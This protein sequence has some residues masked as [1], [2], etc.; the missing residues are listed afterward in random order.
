MTLARLLQPSIV[1][2]EDADLIA[3]DREDMNN[4]CS[5]VMLNKLLN[6]MD[7][8]KADADILFLLT[9]NRPESLES[10]LASRP[11]RV[12]QAIEFPP[13][14]ETGRQKLFSL[15]AA[16]MQLNEALMRDIVKRTEGVS[17][18]FVK[19]FVRRSIQFHIERDGDGNLSNDDINRALDEMLH[20][21]GVL[22]Q[23]LLGA[24]QEIS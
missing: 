10:A 11:G 16:D 24:Q 4:I 6:E 21:G 20:A 9:T 13:P 5:E 18:A 22:N 7:G 1:V 2:I 23:R 14:D 17:A 3:R 15:Y 8:L 12:D 19:E